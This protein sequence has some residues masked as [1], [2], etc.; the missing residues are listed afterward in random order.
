[1]KISINGVAYDLPKPTVS[2]YNVEGIRLD[3]VDGLSLYCDN[4]SGFGGDTCVWWGSDRYGSMVGPKEGVFTKGDYITHCENLWKY[5]VECRI[6][7]AKETTDFFS[8]Y[9]END[10]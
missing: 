3:F 8:K 9:K 2:K 10:Q 4:V 6:E 5:T 1:M 7:K